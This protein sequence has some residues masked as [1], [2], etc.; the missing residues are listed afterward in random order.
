VCVH[1]IHSFSAGCHPSAMVYVEGMTQSHQR[2]GINPRRE[3]DPTLGMFLTVSF[4][5]PYLSGHMH[6]FPRSTVHDAVL[7]AILAVCWGTAYY[8][9]E[10]G[11]H[12]PRLRNV[13][14]ITGRLTGMASI[15]AL[16]ATCY[17]LIFTK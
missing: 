14:V 10:I 4:A 3:I 8:W 5:L 7:A 17:Y 16:Y 9:V 6:W 12:Y 13:I 1:A 15:A 11:I 2:R